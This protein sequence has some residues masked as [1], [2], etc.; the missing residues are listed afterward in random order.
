T[1]RQHPLVIRMRA[2]TDHWAATV[3]CPLSQSK[4]FTPRV[5]IQQC[6]RHRSPQAKSCCGRGQQEALLYYKS[7]SGPLSATIL[8]SRRGFYPLFI[9]FCASRYMV[10]HAAAKDALAV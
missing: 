10:N 3:P 9:D 6:A 7:L 8:T 1:A 4:A 5:A 2:A